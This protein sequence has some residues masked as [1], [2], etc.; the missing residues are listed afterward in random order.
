MVRRDAPEHVRIVKEGSK[1]IHGMY[2]E[3]AF[4]R[5]DDGRVIG[6]LESHHG[7]ITRGG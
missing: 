7:A 6:T 4:G 3:M 5:F 2:G 1:K